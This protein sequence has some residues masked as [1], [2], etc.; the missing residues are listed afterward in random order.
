MCRLFFFL[1]TQRRRHG[2]NIPGIGRR[3][4]RGDRP[5][6]KRSRVTCPRETNGTFWCG[7][8]HPRCE[9]H[10]FW[11]SRATKVIPSEPSRSDLMMITTGRSDVGRVI[12]GF[13]R[14]KGEY[15]FRECCLWK[16]ERWT[17]Q[18]VAFVYKLLRCCWCCWCKVASRCKRAVKWQGNN[19][20]NHR[21]ADWMLFVFE[22]VCYQQP[23]GAGAGCTESCVLGHLWHESICLRNRSIR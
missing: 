12:A 5:R 23:S 4:D 7:V 2:S 14:V 10:A 11:L 1:R 6:K 16:S 9:E 19:G 17:M 22:S 21:W 20:V 8:C 18:F 13:T 3:W 15:A